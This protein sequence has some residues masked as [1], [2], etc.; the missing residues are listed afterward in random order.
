LKHLDAALKALRA[1]VI[2]EDKI[3]ELILARQATGASNAT[4]NRSLAALRQMFRLSAKWVKNPPN[5]AALM[6]DEPPARKGFLERNQYLQL[7]AALPEHL[8]PIFT[9]G[10]NTGMRRGELTNLTWRHVDLASG[11]IRLGAEDTKNGEPRTI[12]YGIMPELNELMRRLREQSASG[13]VFTRNGDALGSFRKAWIR[14][15]IKT[16]LGRMLWACP[17]CHAK[18]EVTRQPWPPERP[19]D[20]SLVCACGE[21]TR[22]KYAGLIFHDLRRSAVRNMRRAGVSESVIMKISGHETPEVFQRYNIK[23]RRDLVEAMEKLAE[24]HRVEDARLDKLGA[25]PI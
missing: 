12:P 14:A 7:L 24:F 5:F 3:N 4:I 17:R 2:T 11:E 10:Y 21:T 15:C 18:V 1:S 16:A 22:W 8:R 9:F 19:K 13:L 20:Q 23:D 25:R 6:L